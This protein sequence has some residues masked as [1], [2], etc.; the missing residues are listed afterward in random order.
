MREKVHM[1]IGIRL[2]KRTILEG[3]ALSCPVSDMIAVSKPGNTAVPP[4]A[5]K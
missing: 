2:P 4:P 3:Q 1:G 5:D